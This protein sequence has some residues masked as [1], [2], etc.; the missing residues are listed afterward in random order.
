MKKFTGYEAKRQTAREVLPAGGYVAKILGAKEME[1]SWGNVLAIHFDIE[2]GEFQGFFARDY[3]S[4]TNEDR[5]WRGVYR[6]T[7][8]KDDGSEKDGW[9]KNTFNGAMW[10]IEESNPGYHWN[11]D[12]ESLAGKTVGVIYRN[13][14][15]EK[16]GNT[17]WTTEAGM[18]ESA[19][20]IRSGRY[21]PMKDKP[22]KKAA[23]TAANTR[24]GSAADDDLPF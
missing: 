24:R 9:T 21:K 6:L 3:E 4:N 12:E 7:E 5:K 20:A 23:G 2:E 10:A 22:L 17:G 15:W 13:R 1:Y 8:P 14:E 19:D 16:D 18:L 11:W